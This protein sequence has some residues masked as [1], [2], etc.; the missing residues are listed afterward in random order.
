MA[1]QL[2]PQDAHAQEVNPVE[3]DGV[4]QEVDREEF[5]QS[6]PQDLDS[7]AEVIP[8]KKTAS[9]IT[10][11]RTK[12]TYR[13]I[14]FFIQILILTKLFKTKWFELKFTGGCFITQ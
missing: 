2:N 10:I 11:T 8:P 7:P 13:N 4:D 12:V 3:F 5:E 1:N 9:K 14:P 6:D